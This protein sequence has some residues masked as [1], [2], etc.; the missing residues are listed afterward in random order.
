MVE[1]ILDGRQP[2][3]LQLNDLL[4]GFS[5]EWERQSATLAAGKIDRGEQDAQVVRAAP[6]GPVC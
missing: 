1:A 3:D 4:K 5:L 6:V 2:A